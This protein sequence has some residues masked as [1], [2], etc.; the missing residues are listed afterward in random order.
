M[1]LLPNG[2]CCL[3]FLVKSEALDINYTEDF[4]DAM[5]AGC[6]IEFKVKHFGFTDCSGSCFYESQWGKNRIGYLIYRIIIFGYAL[7]WIIADVVTI[8]QPYYAIFLTNWSE[9]AGCLYL[10]LA[11]CIAI[12]GVATEGKDLRWFHKVVWLVFEAVIS[13]ALITDILFWGLLSSR[14]SSQAL[15]H[16]FNIHEHVVAYLLL[17]IDL[18]INKIPLRFLHFPYTAGYGLTY[19]IFTLIL[20]GAGVRSA[21]YPPLD[22]ANSPGIAVLY[23]LV[24]SLIAMPVAHILHWG[25]YHLRAFIARSCDVEDSPLEDRSVENIEMGGETNNAFE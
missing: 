21:V 8:P 22:W 12:Y 6:R 10:F 2:F 20:H 16:Q 3:C 25:F 5:T 4:V 23:S 15:A 17:L 11:L 24:A 18:F 14:L 9:V 19:A 1:H 7:A 13:G